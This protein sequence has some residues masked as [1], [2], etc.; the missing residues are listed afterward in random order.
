MRANNFE[1]D[2]SSPVM[3]TL[4]L[5]IVLKEVRSEIRAQEISYA[6][7]VDFLKKEWINLT[8]FMNHSTSKLSYSIL[9]Y[10]GNTLTY[11][12]KGNFLFQFPL[13]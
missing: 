1:G 6:D 4:Y 8:D 11:I 2:G 10:Q 7:D 13:F 12:L 9:L 5:E 3:F